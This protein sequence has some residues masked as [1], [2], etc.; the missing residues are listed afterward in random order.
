MAF[1]VDQFRQA[2][3]QA[4]SQSP[5][6]ARVFER[7]KMTSTFTSEEKSNIYNLKKAIKLAM[8]DNGI[9][10]YSNIDMVIAGGFFSTMFGES[11]HYND[12][13]V[14]ILNNHAAL[15]ENCIN[16][17]IQW[18]VNSSNNRVG[19][20]NPYF[21]NPHIMATAKNSVN[22]VQ[23]ILTDYKT[24]EEL[25]ASFDFVH[26]TISYDTIKDVLYI[27]RRAYDANKNKHLINNS[28]T[29]P[30][31]SWRLQKF[32]DR[33]WYVPSVKTTFAPYGSPLGVG[34]TNVNAALSYN[35]T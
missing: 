17:T 31:P 11:S 19:R 21:H 22:K 23:Y 3:D 4:I 29:E 9:G 10:N 16:N 34:V 33:G 24:R 5:A 13:D 14:F 12:L 28:K 18:K 32:L 7:D 1:N 15:F 26:C 27:T 20:M 8:N 2:L 25:I 35:N 6:V 30:P